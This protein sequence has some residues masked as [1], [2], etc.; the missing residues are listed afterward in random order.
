M[1]NTVLILRDPNK[2]EPT[3]GAPTSFSRP[4]IRFA[5]S[6]MEVKAHLLRGMSRMEA[7]LF[8]PPG[9]VLLDTGT[10]DLEIKSELTRW[11]SKHPRLGNVQILLAAELSLAA[12][13]WSGL[14][15]LLRLW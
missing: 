15:R 3:P 4:R 12:R 14:G 6:V 2:A 7:G 9:Y 11:I 8:A 13:L 1:N 5:K 10:R